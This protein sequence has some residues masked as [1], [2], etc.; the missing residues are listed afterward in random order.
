VT[1]N[2][3][4]SLAQAYETAL[5]PRQNV[6]SRAMEDFMTSPKVKLEDKTHY[7]GAPGDTVI[8]RAVDYFR[9]TG[10]RVEIYAADGSFL[11]GGNAIQ[12]VNGIDWTYTATQV[13]NPMAGSKIIAIASDVPGNKGT[14]ETIL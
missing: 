6:Y 9:V 12:N 11:E 5:R 13:N 8:V 1:T 3:D 4:Q 14:L 7:Q 10:V 2:P